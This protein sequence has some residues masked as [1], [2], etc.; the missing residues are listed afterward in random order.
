MVSL[1][2]SGTP[3]GV[4]VDVTIADGETLITVSGTRDAAVIVRSPSGE[5]VYLPPEEFED[6]PAD[7]PSHDSHYEGRS[8]DQSPY[9]E[10][11]P[12]DS[13][14]GA[15]E[16]G[17]RSRGRDAGPRPIGVETTASGFRVYHPEPTTD[18][19]FVAE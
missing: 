1:S 11:V 12:D 14:Y 16:S 8:P 3:E 15:T 18:V 17:D 6:D 9:E 2:M 13:P 10:V 19:R 7:G 5:E 4:S